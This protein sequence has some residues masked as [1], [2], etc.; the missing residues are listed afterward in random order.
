MYLRTPHIGTDVL[1]FNVY[2]HPRG[3]QRVFSDTR[4]RNALAGK[5][6]D[7]DRH[8]PHHHPWKPSGI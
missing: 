6:L 4:F 2:E 5:G 3:R 1:T 7:L 8:L